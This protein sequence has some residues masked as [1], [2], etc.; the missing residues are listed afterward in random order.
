MKVSSIL[1]VR[2]VSGGS[3]VSVAAVPTVRTVAT[4]L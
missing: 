4:L 2:E 3:V 1:N